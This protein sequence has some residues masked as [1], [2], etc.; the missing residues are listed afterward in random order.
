MQL[1]EVEKIMGVKFPKLFER[2][3]Q[4]GMLDY[5]ACAD[6]NNSNQVGFFEECM[7]DCLPVT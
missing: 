4:S 3:N 6:R 5:L 7:S 1:N 2:I